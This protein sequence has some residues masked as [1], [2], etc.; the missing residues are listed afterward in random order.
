[1]TV[2]LT[3]YYLEVKCTVTVIRDQRRSGSAVAHRRRKGGTA[4]LDRTRLA[5]CKIARH[6]RHSRRHFDRPIGDEHRRS[7][8]RSHPGRDDRTRA[9]RRSA[10]AA[11]RRA[12]VVLSHTG[13]GRRDGA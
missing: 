11:T 13:V 10:R 3:T 12:R 4:G 9:D 5:A 6:T 7:R 1:V 2:H 8:L